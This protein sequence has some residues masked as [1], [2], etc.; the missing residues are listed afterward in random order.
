MVNNVISCK[1]SKETLKKQ[2]H[3]LCK[4]G[5]R[6]HEW[7][8]IAQKWAAEV[9]PRFQKIQ[10]IC[11]TTKK[12]FLAINYGKTTS[13][14][15]CFTSYFC[16]RIKICGP[17]P[18]S[19]DKNTVINALQSIFVFPICTGCPKKKYLSEISGLEMHME[20]LDRFG[21]CQIILDHFYTLDFFWPVGPF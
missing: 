14:T 21:P 20:N 19:G 2:N 5:S 7:P 15:I 10:P 4:F 18:T 13:G 8:K 1:K 16:Y 6:A 17:H 9:D 3:R 12:S 11:G